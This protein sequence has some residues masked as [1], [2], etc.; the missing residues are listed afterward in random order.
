MI[1]KIPEFELISTRKLTNRSFESHTKRIQQSLP[2]KDSKFAPATWAVPKYGYTH[3]TVFKPVGDFHPRTPIELLN[4]LNAVL[5]PAGVPTGFFRTWPEGDRLIGGICTTDPD[6]LKEALDKIPEVEWVSTEPLTEQSFAVYS[7]R[8]QKSLPRK[9]SQFEAATWSEPKA[10]YTHMTIFKPVGDFHP[11]TPIQ[12]LNK[13]NATLFPAGVRTGY[14]RTWPEGD[15]LIG[16]ICTDD[17]DGLKE[18]LDKIPEVEWVSTEPLT[19]KSFAEYSERPQKSLPPKDSQLEP[20]TWSEPKSGY[21][22]MVVFKPI[23]DFHPRTPIELLKKLNAT[24]FPAGVRTGYFR[25]FPVKDQLVGAI[26]TDVPEGLKEV[27]DEIPELTLVDT[28]QLTAKSFA[29]YEKRKQES[30]GWTTPEGGYPYLTVFAPIN[31]FHPKTPRE[32]L[33]KL[34]KTLFP[35]KVRTGYFRTWPENGRLVGGICT[36]DSE[37][38]KSVLKKIPDLKWVRTDILNAKSFEKHSN[39]KQESLP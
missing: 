30:L 26:C 17:P 4:K 29:A 5:F 36:D 16:G 25:T 15:R 27:I 32:L 9:D 1:E 33:D 8:P 39:R 11:R 6:A 10:G 28:E 7:A 23:G 38:L 14:F 22:H 18:V 35:A 13:L 34:N 12:L 24:L 37:G 20:T 2:R 19:E 3:M 21:T 31:N